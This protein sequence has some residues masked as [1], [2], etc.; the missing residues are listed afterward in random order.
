MSDSKNEMIVFGEFGLTQPGDTFSA[1][2]TDSGR[3][4]IKK[5]LDGGRIKQSATRYPTTGTIFKTYT[6]KG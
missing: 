4:V 6:T 1:Y 5:T 2:V 3:Q